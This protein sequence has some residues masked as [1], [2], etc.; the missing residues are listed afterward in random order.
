MSYV[1]LQSNSLRLSVDLN[2]N[3]D[4]NT[5][6]EL[7][8][9]Y[10]RNE[11]P[12]LSDNKISSNTIDYSNIIDVVNL[13]YGQHYFF[14][15]YIIT[16]IG[17]LYSLNQIEIFIPENGPVMTSQNNFSVLDG[18]VSQIYPY[19]TNATGPW[20]VTNSDCVEAPCITTGQSYGGFVEFNSE[21]PSNGYFEFWIKTFDPGY[22]NRIPKIEINGV[23]TSDIEIV[24]GSASTGSFS[25]I[26]LRVNNV[27]AGNINITIDFEEFSNR[28]I[29]YTLDEFKFYTNQ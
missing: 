27:S 25:F 23:E 11:N 6:I 28:I 18:I 1:S 19:G 14:K 7:G 24:D 21:N 4:Q 10:S 16:D 13:D 29:T 5:I 9:V 20:F 15:S 17:V 2:S 12:I 22:P 26:K 3:I 8:V